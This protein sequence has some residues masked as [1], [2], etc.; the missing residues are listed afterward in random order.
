MKLWKLILIN[1]VLTLAA[2]GSLGYAIKLIVDNGGLK[3]L[4]EGKK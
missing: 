2:Y 3:V 1:V 4:W